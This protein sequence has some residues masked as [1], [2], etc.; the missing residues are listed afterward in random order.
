MKRNLRLWTCYVLIQH[1]LKYLKIKYSSLLAVLTI[2]CLYAVKQVSAQEVEPAA[3]A[4]SEIKPLQIGDTIP[5]Y[6]WRLPLQW[7]VK[8]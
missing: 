3:T 6:V 7:T 1:K 4:V 2:M 5:E 8:I